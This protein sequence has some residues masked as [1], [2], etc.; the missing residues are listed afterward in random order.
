MLNTHIMYAWNCA[1]IGF[2]IVVLVAPLCVAFS[3]QRVI[4]QQTSMSTFTAPD[5]R[6]R[7]DYSRALVACRRHPKQPDH[8]LLS[9]SCNAYTPVCANFSGD[10]PETVA[11]IAYP[12]S[13]MKGTNF[14]AAAFAVN[15]LRKATTEA[16][17]LNVPEPP[18]HVGTAQIQV[19]NGVA[20][21]VVEADGVAAG[22]LIDA[23]VYRAFHQNK[24]Y[25]VDIRIAYSNPADAGP[26]T[27]NFDSATVRGR[28]KQILETFRFSE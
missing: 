12:A 1:R 3:A 21:T 2:L 28:L 22:N 23:Y 4:P 6:F 8:W 20:F 14:Q 25:E 18:P 19:V 9:D 10:S 27:M 26:G 11:C 24:C 16:E 7:F 15:E 5:G 17:C 13:E